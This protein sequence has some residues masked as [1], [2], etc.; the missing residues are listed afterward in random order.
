VTYLTLN[1]RHGGA[2]RILKILDYLKAQDAD[3]ICLTEFRNSDSGQK[4]ISGL[5]KFGYGYYWVPE[6]NP[7][8]NTVAIFSRRQMAPV[9]FEVPPELRRYIAPVV[10]DGFHVL[11][12]YFP[13]GE[14]KR[15]VFDWLIEVSAK[16]ISLSSIIM[17]DF[18]TGLHY[19]DESGA[20][21]FCADQF[22]ALLYLGWQDTY[23]VIHGETKAFTWL[24]NKGNGFRVDHALVT[25]G[26]VVQSA[27]YDDATRESGMTDH[28]SMKIQIV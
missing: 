11:G 12:V 6:L 25:P 10:F 23:R 5:A 28:S 1:I 17:G 13:Q 26:I 20:T 15:P 8:A 9:R 3:M 14:Y 21:F 18:N 7:K 22:K 2:K 19:K 27:E 16:L 24:S 4:I